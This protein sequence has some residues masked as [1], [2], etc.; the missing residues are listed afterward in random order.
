MS[1]V[2]PIEGLTRLPVEEE[3]S[4]HKEVFD[5]AEVE[6]FSFIN[7]ICFESDFNDIGF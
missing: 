4:T 3:V 5:M 1:Q 2:T 7:Y 6:G